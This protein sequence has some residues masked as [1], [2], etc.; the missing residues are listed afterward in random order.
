[1]KIDYT[2]VLNTPIDPEAIGLPWGAGGPGLLATDQEVSD[3]ARRITDAQ[4]EKLPALFAAHGVTLGNWSGLCLA[5]AAEHVPGFKLKNKGGRPSKWT[6]YQQ[7]EFVCDVEELRA[8][9]L[10]IPES[11]KLVVR[12]EPW[13]A[14]TEEASIDRL[15][16]IFDDARKQHPMVVSMIAKS[17]AFDRLTA[18]DAPAIGKVPRG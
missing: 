2:G 3:A 7:A 4:F 9:G 18:S 6:A 16:D 8:T 14:L 12:R 15:K 13:K 10:S 17:R 1:M 11:I 5:L